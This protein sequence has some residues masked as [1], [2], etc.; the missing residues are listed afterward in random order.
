MM[1]AQ[2]N[3]KKCGDH[4]IVID[5]LGHFVCSADSL[6]EAG[7]DIDQMLGRDNDGYGEN[8]DSS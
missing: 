5:R 1:Y 4:Y 8:V 7:A 3:I 6:A 2:Y